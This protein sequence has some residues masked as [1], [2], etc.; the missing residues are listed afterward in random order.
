KR[1]P[2]LR[3]DAGYWGLHLIAWIHT[4]LSARAVIPWNPKRQKQRD[5]LPPTWTA[6]EL[7]KRTSFEHFFCRILI[8]FHLQ[9]PPDFG[10]SKV[11]TRV[12]LSYAAL[13]VIAIAAWQAGSLD[14]IRSSRLVLAN[15]LEGVES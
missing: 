2:P 4:T 14:I 1:R 7:D 8:F 3:L 6:E 12:A 9:R 11:E 13:W 5:D 15:I 10:W